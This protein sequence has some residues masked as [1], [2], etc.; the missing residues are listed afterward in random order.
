MQELHELHMLALVEQDFPI[1]LGCINKGII[2]GEITPAMEDELVYMEKSK[3]RYLNN[4][5]DF[6]LKTKA[7]TSFY[8][9]SNFEHLFNCTS[10]ILQQITFNEIRAMYTKLINASRKFVKQLFWFTKKF[11]F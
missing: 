5:L 7:L 3:W 2:F 10:D 6:Q 11:T 1:M 4:M 8:K 9:G